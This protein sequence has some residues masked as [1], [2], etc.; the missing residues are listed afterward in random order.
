MNPHT[1]SIGT[2]VSPSVVPLDIIPPSTPAPE[3]TSES[4][5]TP[6]ELVTSHIPLVGHLVREVLS[7]VPGHVDR[8][9]LTSAGL[10]ALVQAAQ[11]FDAARGVPFA[12]YASTRIRGALLDELRGI[13]WATRSVRRT[14]RSLDETRGRLT[15]DLGRVPT[16][17]EVAS[18]QG[19]P[20][21]DVLSNREDLAR[22]QVASLQA[23]DAAGGLAGSLV[24]ST[25]TPEQAIEHAE[26]LTYLSEAIAEL[27][28]RLRRVVEGYFL[29]EQPM[30]ELATELGVTESRISQLRAE[31]MV[32]LRDALNS[33]LDPSLVPAHDRPEGVAARRREAYFSAVAERH[34]AAAVFSPRIATSA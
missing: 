32:L 8:D 23:V 1:G 34:A 13:D 5:P 20:L 16:D 19:V 10:T 9:D 28:E 6:D 17:A 4:V 26:L 33:Q 3:Q 29:A 30:A 24:C 25:P 12:R 31:A 27:P 15:Q 2:A 22:A 18:A 7:R 14:A 11:G 21:E